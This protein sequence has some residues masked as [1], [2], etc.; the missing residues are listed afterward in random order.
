MPR[1]AAL[2]DMDRTLI[3]KNTASLYTR[4]RRDLGEAGLKDS[5]LVGWWVLQYTLGLVNAEGVARKALG[6]YKG[7][8]ELDMVARCREWFPAYVL[9]HLTRA[10]REAVEQHKRAGD[11]LAIVTGSTR[12]AA[13]PLADALGI[14]HV[15]SSEID[16]SEDGSF[17]G[18]VRLPLCLGSGK[19]E[20]ARLFL[21]GHEVALEDATFYS[22]SVTDLPLLEAVG[23]PIV[24]NPDFRLVRVAKKR[25]WPA[26]IW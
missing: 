10:A 9:P 3:R 1:R 23:R 7:T 22:D 14:D 18:E 15:V 20:R 12:Y 6:A 25:G 11:L 19:L 4:Y 16:V 17:T 8:A 24:V 26:L 13:L 21:S 5:F 2:F